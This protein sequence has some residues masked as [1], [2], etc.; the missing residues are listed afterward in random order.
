MTGAPVTAEALVE[1]VLAGICRLEGDVG[2]KVPP[3]TA[4][5]RLVTFAYGRRAAEASFW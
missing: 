3:E 4:P 2:G 5:R 1:L